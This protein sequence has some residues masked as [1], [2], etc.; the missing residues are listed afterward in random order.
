MISCLSI[1]SRLK[2]SRFEAA[3]IN[4]RL[5]DCDRASASQAHKY[6]RPCLSSGR[7][8]PLRRARRQSPRASPRARRIRQPTSRPARSPIANGPNRE[9]ELDR[10]SVD[11]ARKRALEE[12]ALRLYRRGDSMRCHEAGATPTTT[13]TFPIYGQCHRGRE[14][15][16][17]GRLSSHDLEQ[18]HH[19]RGLKK[20]CRALPAAAS[21]SA[22]LR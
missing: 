20:C 13:G 18:L 5:Q 1:A 6:R 11:V 19:V 10:R 9:A 17:R 22:R 2:P 12:Q 16:G 14:H 8:G 3:A 15:V 7:N 21:L 4:R